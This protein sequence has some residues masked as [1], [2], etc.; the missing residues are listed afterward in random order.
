MGWALALNCG[1]KHR[2]YTESA[3]SIHDKDGLE[4]VGIHEPEKVDENIE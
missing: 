2:F 1:F 4:A 3:C